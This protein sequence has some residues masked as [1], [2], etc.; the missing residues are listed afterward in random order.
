MGIRWKSTWPLKISIGKLRTS[1]L[2]LGNVRSIRTSTG[3]LWTSR[4]FPRISTG[5][6]QQ[7]INWIPS[8][9]NRNP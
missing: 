6:I 5:N 3:P 7:Q 1:A 9:S 4:G 2:L 8:G